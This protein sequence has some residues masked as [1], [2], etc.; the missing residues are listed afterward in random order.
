[1]S[2]LARVFIALF[3]LVRAMAIVAADSMLLNVLHDALQIRCWL[4][5]IGVTHWFS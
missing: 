1:M 4:A 5:V 3:W 2:L